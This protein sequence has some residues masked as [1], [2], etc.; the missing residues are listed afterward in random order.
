M[1]ISQSKS[2][3]NKTNPQHFFADIGK[4]ETCAKCYRKIL[5]STVVGARQSFQFFR[6]ITWFLGNKRTLSKFSILDFASLN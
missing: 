6:E 5:N 1:F 2:K 4:T 3:Q